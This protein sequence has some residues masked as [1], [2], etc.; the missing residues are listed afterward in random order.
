[1]TPTGCTTLCNRG[2]V[3]M[4]NFNSLNEA[5]KSVEMGN[6]GVGGC[7]LEIKSNNLTFL[8]F[9]Q[10]IREWKTRRV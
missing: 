3:V 7:E 6:L 2:L 1:M 8:F 9:T 4:V 10:P 5:T